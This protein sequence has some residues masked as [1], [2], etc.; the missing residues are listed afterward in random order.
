MTKPSTN[1][2]VNVP[3]GIYLLSGSIYFQKSGSW[4]ILVQFNYNIDNM[5]IDIETLGYF[6]LCAS[7]DPWGEQVCGIKQ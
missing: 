3:E 6:H 4:Q 1:P 5:N 7:L 2:T